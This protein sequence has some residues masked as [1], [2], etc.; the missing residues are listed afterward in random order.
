MDLINSKT[1]QARNLAINQLSGK[2]SSLIRNLRQEIIEILAN[3]E[4]NIDYP[5][6]EDIEELT[7]QKLV[8]KIEKVKEEI[9]KIIK[10][11]E[12]GK[13]IK[14]GI[15]TVIVGRPNVGKSSILNKLINEEKAIV[16]EIEGTTRDI[17]EGSVNINGIIL[18]IIDTAGIRK[19]EDIVEKIGVSKSLE[20]IDKADLIL[21]VLNNNQK[22]TDDDRVILEKIKN[23]NHIIIINK[24]DLENKLDIKELEN[25]QIVYMSAINNEGI[26]DLKQ[27]IKEI[28]NL[29][30]IMTSDFTYLTNARSI[31][32]LKQCLKVIKEIEDGINQNNSIDMIE[33]DIKRVWSL[34]GEI[35]GET[36]DEELIDQIFKQF[37]LGK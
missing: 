23:K 27:K 24:I 30:K 33:I 18:N 15:K 5:E 12:N 9:K 32:L 31:S 10:E 22:L 3:I 6:Y 28:F 37:C 26:D 8:P 14:E 25:R 35:I 36:Y 17:V 2:V 19:T 7:N 16:T 29:E 1:E 21:Y 20:L 13:I 34:L 4:V 11:S